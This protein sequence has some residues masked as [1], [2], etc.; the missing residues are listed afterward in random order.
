LHSNQQCIS[1]PVFPHPHQHLLLL[2]PLNMAILTGVRW[3]LS[4]VLIC[5]F[6]ISREVEHFFM[7]LLAIC[8]SPFENSLFNSCAHFFIGMLILWGLSFWVSCRF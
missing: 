8:T 4:V 5:I 6:F 3:N 1:V 2:L 7:Y